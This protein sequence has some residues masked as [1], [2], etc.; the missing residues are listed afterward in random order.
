[1]DT[2]SAAEEA[3]AA[4]KMDCLTALLAEM[5]HTALSTSSGDLP[6]HTEQLTLTGARIR[7]HVGMHQFRYRILPIF[8]RDGM[9]FEVVITSNTE[10]NARRQVQSQYPASQYQVAYLGEVR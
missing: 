3:E 7:S 9:S 4:T 10:A 5:V 1:V 6:S 8:A 2:A